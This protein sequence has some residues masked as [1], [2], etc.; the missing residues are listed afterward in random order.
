VA[1]AGKE[2]C[3][4]MSGDRA[5]VACFPSSCHTSHYHGNKAGVSTMLQYSRTQ[6]AVSF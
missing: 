4:P 1:S 6:L 2:L 5:M 3:F